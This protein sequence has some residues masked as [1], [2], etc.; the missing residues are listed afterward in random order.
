M[1]AATDAGLKGFEK[2]STKVVDHVVD[3]VTRKPKQ[4]SVPKHSNIQRSKLR[5]TR[6]NLISGSCI[7]TIHDF[8][9]RYK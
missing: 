4:Q 5:Q 1:S 6:L 3:K 2:G 8:V 7:A 9:Q